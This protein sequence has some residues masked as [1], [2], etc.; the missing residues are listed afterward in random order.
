VKHLKEKAR[1]KLFFTIILHRA[2]T[3]VH[4]CK[5]NFVVSGIVKKENC[6]L[7]NLKKVLI[8]YYEIKIKRNVG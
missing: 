7:R 6:Q 2:L 8:I 1:A 4:L 3:K 5:K